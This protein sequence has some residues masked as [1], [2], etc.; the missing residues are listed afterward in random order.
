MA[1]SN[2]GLAIKYFFG[3]FV[4]GVVL[5]PVWWYTRGL[6]QAGR[7]AVGAF[8][9][10]NRTL[11]WSIWAKNLFVPMY[12]ETEWSGRIISF[13]VRFTMLIVRGV[14]VLVWGVGALA[15][16]VFYLIAPPLAVI[17]ILYNAVGS[18]AS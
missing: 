11:G 17:G 2:A 12:G 10:A 16:F 4:G 14:G 15:L 9:S 18:I 6:M 7:W 1:Q 5:F 13:G 3:D 8:S